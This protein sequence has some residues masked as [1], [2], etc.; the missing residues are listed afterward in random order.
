MLESPLLRAPDDPSGGSFVTGPGPSTVATHRPEAARS[1]PLAELAAA[2]PEARVR[3]DSAATVSGLTY[4]SSEVQP[5]WM[6][7]CVPGAK[8]DGHRFAAEAC[9]SEASSLV[10]ERWLDVGCAQV[11]VPSTRVAMG[12]MSAG[13][14]DRPAEHLVLIGVTGTN[15]KTTTTYLLESIFR[16]AGCES[17][18]G[19]F[20][21][22]GPRRRPPT[23]S[24][25]C[26]RW[27]TRAYGQPPW[28]SPPTGFTSTE[29]TGSGSPAPC[30]RTSPRIT[31]TTTGRW[32]ST[33]RQ[34]PVCSPRISPTERSSTT[35]HPRA[36]G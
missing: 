35:T 14:F 1:K 20:P 9:R 34:R 18:A 24:G 36:A 8:V 12:P 27:W 32:R 2:I 11:L 26:P 3:G 19:P 13:F 28:R 17:T 6:F 5:G 29:W 31:S 21:S 33:S 7:F 10:V 25:S 30:S 22:T 23:S 15:G 4:R 16:A